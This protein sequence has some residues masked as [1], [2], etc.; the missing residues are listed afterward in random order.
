M[1]NLTLQAELEQI[2][3]ESH[4]DV[5][6]AIL[7]ILQTAVLAAAP[8]KY[9]GWSNFGKIDLTA[10]KE[11]YNKAVKEYTKALQQLFESEE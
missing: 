10:D 6:Q 8:E 9:T 7:A 3:N 2:L 5:V 4:A 11:G 1:S